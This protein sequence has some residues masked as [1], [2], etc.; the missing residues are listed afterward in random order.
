MAKLNLHDKTINA[1]T[2]ISMAAKSGDEKRLMKAVKN[3]C[4]LANEI[5]EAHNNADH[6]FKAI[7]LGSLHKTLM[8]RISEFAEVR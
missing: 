1:L 2:E 7:V 4:K 6:H 3:G 5:A 8:G